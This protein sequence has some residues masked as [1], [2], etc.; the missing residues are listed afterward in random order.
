MTAEEYL[1]FLEGFWEL[2]ADR[3]AREVVEIRYSKL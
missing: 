2:F 3:R 1:E